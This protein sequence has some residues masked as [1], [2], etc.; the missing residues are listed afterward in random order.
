MKE[1]KLKS[2]IVINRS[3]ALMN[4]KK[5]KKKFQVQAPFFVD[6]KHKKNVLTN[7]KNLFEST[8]GICIRGRFYTTVKC[9]ET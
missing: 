2:V 8:S 6:S 7:C 5:K 1:N 4:A 3:L 9:T